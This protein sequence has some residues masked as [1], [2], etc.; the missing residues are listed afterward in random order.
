MKYIKGFSLLKT[1]LVIFAFLLVLY[2]GYVYI[3]KQ[4]SDPKNGIT[5]GTDNSN[6]DD[7]IGQVFSFDFPDNIGDYSLIKKN[8]N[9]EEKCNTIDGSE[10]CIKSSEVIYLNEGIN[11]EIHIYPSFISKGD[12]SEINKA[13]VEM[14]E[15]KIQEGLYKIENHEI[16][17]FPE[18]GFNYITAQSYL[19]DNKNDGSISYIQKDIDLENEVISY[20]MNAY[21]VNNNK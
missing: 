1:I 21:P 10:Q 3:S 5:C 2:I 7:C 11:S 8:F 19:I 15:K 18:L 20:F 17:W 6:Q 16:I 9:L 4:T 13:I 14:A 12:F